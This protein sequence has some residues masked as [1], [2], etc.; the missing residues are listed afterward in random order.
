M[1]SHRDHWR[2]RAMERTWREMPEDEWQVCLLRARIIIGEMLRSRRA[3]HHVVM[4]KEEQKMA[5]EDPSL[6]MDGIGE[7]I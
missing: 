2:V 5:N 4:R 1:Q 7:W 6:R 3:T